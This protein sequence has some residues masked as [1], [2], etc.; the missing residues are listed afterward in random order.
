MP[1]SALDLSAFATEVRRLAGRGEPPLY[2]AFKRLLA[3]IY[4]SSYVVDSLLRTPGA[5]FPDFTVALGL[6]LI[7]WVEVKH[8]GIPIDPLPGPDQA[9]FDR[10]REALPHIVL[11]NGWN[12][13]LYRGGSEIDGVELPSDWLTGAHALSQANLAEA[14]RFFTVISAL[15]PTAAASYDEAV[16]LLAVS[17][18]L[19]EQAVLDSEA[20]LPGSLAQALQSFTELLQTNP[21]D[22]SEWTFPNF[23]DALAQTCV[24][25]YLMARVEAGKDVTPYSAHGALST[26]QH[27]FLR[28]TLHAMVAPAETLKTRCLACSGQR[29]TLSTPRRRCSPARRATGSTCLTC[30]S[31]SSPSTSP[32]TASSSASSTRPSR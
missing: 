9:R 2:P 32:P 27:P 4:G 21:H 1:P 26:V 10:Y 19:I 5:G 28:A 7:N 12:W 22:T 30:T 13:R 23:A 17:A 14:E 8:P 11:T 3:A 18:R 15:T 16:H 31:R 25:G 6:R 20:I 24:F 29:A